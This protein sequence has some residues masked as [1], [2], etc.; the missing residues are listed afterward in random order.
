MCGDTACPSCGPAQG[1]DLAF[2]QVCEWI[3]G[4]LL[5]DMPPGIDV[6]WLAEDLADRLGRAGQDVCDAIY[7]AARRDQQVALAEGRGV[8]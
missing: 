1:H 7:A 4:R 6:D 3:A 8:R 5:A 2:E